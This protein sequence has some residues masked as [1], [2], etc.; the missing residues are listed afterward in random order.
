MSL[1]GRRVLIVE[2]EAIVGLSL[3]EDL[4]DINFIP[5]GPFAS[6]EKGIETLGSERVDLALV[7]LNL[8]GHMSFSLI[9]QLVSL[10]IPVAIMSGYDDGS[11]PGRFAALPRLGKPF[12]A[13]M[14]REVLAA[15]ETSNSR[16]SDPEQL[17]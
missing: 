15:L 5:V 3:C 16:P 10:Q 6:L 12:S 2:D 14:L 1:H 11:I 13:A 9:D 4:Q 17:A 7:D 8:R